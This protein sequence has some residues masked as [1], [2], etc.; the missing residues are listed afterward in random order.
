[1]SLTLTDI[2]SLDGS[3][4]AGAEAVKRRRTVSTSPLNR[5]VSD[6]RKSVN[7]TSI[8]VRFLV[9]PGLEKSFKEW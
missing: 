3:R 1:M 5:R 2:P 4:P 8:D 9:A 6:L 7:R